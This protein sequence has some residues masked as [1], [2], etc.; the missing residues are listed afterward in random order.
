MKLPKLVNGK[1]VAIIA[2]IIGTI[3]IIPSENSSNLH[4]IQWAS[5]WLVGGFFTWKK[6]IWAAII[7]A[8]VALYE[9][10]FQLIPDIKR[11]RA[12]VKVELT[13]FT[14]P[15]SAILAVNITVYSI[16]A[17]M[18]LCVIYYGIYMIVKSKRY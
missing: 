9:L 13:Q 1:L 10:F 3:Y 12:D 7:L 18:L 16:A 8:M 4:N 5:F 2:F 14:L 11:L 15:E 6:K 17:I